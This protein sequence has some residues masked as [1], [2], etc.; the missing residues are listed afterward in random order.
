M[1][2]SNQYPSHSDHKKLQGRG[3]RASQ[4]FTGAARRSQS[5]NRLG[6]LALDPAEQ[7]RL[8]PELFA[9][10]SAQSLKKALAG[11]PSMTEFHTKEWLRKQARFYANQAQQPSAPKP[12]S[13]I[14]R[15]YLMSEQEVK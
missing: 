14:R 3:L 5:S 4:A 11:S 1:N 9:S 8:F 15:Q 10:E 2:W 6:G 12:K 13:V 7:K